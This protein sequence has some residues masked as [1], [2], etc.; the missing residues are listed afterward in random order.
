MGGEAL[1]SLWAELIAV[2]LGNQHLYT[3]ISDFLHFAV[4]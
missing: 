4:L 1:D 3:M 2:F